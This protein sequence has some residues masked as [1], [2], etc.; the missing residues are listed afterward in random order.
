MHSLPGEDIQRQPVY[1][2]DVCRAVEAEEDGDSADE[3]VVEGDE[4]P[5]DVAR[6]N[7][8]A[9]RHEGKEAVPELVSDKECMC[10][11]SGSTRSGLPRADLFEVNTKRCR[12]R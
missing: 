10:G 4:G 5:D 6:P 9:A 11:V 1:E 8:K 12:S 2:N 7:S 3:Q